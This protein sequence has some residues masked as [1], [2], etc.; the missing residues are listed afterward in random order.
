MEQASHQ[1]RAE[2]AQNDPRNKSEGRLFG[3]PMGDLG[4]FPSLVVGLA[5]GFV[6]FFAATFVG[7]VGILFYSSSTHQTV[8][9]AL[10]YREGGLTAGIVV[11]LAAWGFLGRQWLRRVLR[12]S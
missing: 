4:L 2:D 7:I 9:Y 3:I 1:Y 5:L 10:S 6:A 11:A 12:K 8:N